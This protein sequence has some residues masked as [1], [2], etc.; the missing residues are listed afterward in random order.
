M[1]IAP[2]STVMV[3]RGVRLDS[4]YQNTIHFNSSTEQSS[5]FSSKVKYTFSGCTYLRKENVIRVDTIADNLY[6]CNYLM[7]QNT[8][9]GNKWFYA[10]IL[11]VAYVNNQTAE[12]TYQIDVMQTWHFDYQVLPSFVEREHV[13]GDKP[14][15]NLVPDN[16]ELGEYIVDD[17]DGTGHLGRYS[18]VVA[19]TF[20]EDYD[21]VAGG[22]YSN[23]YSGLYYNVFDSGTE[24]ND[25]LEGAGAKVDGVV[26]IFIMPS[27]FVSGVGDSPTT[28][29]VTKQKLDSGPID[30]YTPR[31]NKLYTH[32]YN[33]L[34]CTNL[35]G[36]S[37]VFPY[38][39]FSTDDCQ[40]MLAGDMSCNPQVLLVPLNYKGVPTNYN[41]KMGLEG[42]P[43]CSYNTDTFKVWLS[44]TAATLGLGLISDSATA[45][46]GAVTGNVPMAVGGVSGIANTLAS[47][48]QHAI[49]PRQARGG[50]SNSTMV[51]MRLKDFAFMHM[52][53]QAEFAR[54]IDDYWD[55][56]GY[57]VHEVKVP[58]ISTRPHW[59]YV[60][61]QSVSIVGDVP[62]DDLV[63]IKSCYNNGITF[64]RNGNEVGN[65]S[66]DNRVS[67]Q[68]GE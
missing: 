59:N 23:I 61:T 17:F 35:N 42:F 36:T 40:F 45:V 8:S 38:E 51:A 27:D 22:E 5:F 15:D 67:R 24:V 12:I 26:S 11:N 49:M 16:L 53:I 37:A 25:F 41:E 19:A 21:N 65:Y 58:N 20:N 18:I 10:F 7:F 68:G 9:Y 33:F 6:D 48:Y 64:W 28:Y 31:N 63:Q 46:A 3:L 29:E 13:A 50:Q 14:G 57:P 32:P 44:Q 52:H 66:L 47:V 62:A 55:M 4:S 1:Y 34:Y 43:Q 39:Y 60:K 2:N 56:Y 54:I 30:G